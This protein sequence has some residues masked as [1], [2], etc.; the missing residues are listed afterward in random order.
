MARG[1]IYSIISAICLGSLAIFAKTGLAMGMAPM[2]IVQYRFFF[3]ALLLLSWIG[4]T[5]PHLLRIRP[6][7]LLKA[8]VL[9]AGIYPVQSWLFIKALQ[10]LPASTTSLIYYLYPVVTTL[11]A[12]IFTGLKPNKTI[13][14]SLLLILAGCGLV[15]YNA[16]TQAVDIRGI[17]FILACMVTFSI[18]LTLVQRFTKN[19]EAQRVSIWVIFFMAAAVSCISPPTTILSQPLKGWGIAI[20]LGLIPTAVAISLLYRAIEKIGSAYA[21]MFSTVEPVTTVLLA[22][23]ILDEPM[24][25][26][27]LAGMVLIITG[28]IMPNLGLIREKTIVSAK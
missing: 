13:Y 17:W 9:G 24:D 27:Q 14:Q 6:K 19:D 25:I 1:F 18:Y 8:A 21:A 12:V 10:H 28:I 20:G 2:Q 3:G 4:A 26:I 22:T 5:Q 11:I 15:F 7:G 16:F 23:L